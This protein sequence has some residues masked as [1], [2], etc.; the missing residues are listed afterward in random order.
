V[1]KMNREKEE[2]DA[3]IA[4]SL[5]VLKMKEAHKQIEDVEKLRK[6]LRFSQ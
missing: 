1:E 5:S 3:E 2:L 6:N 4:R